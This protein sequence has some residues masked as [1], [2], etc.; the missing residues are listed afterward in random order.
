MSGGNNTPTT[1]LNVKDT[2][3]YPL[4]NGGS[5]T[6]IVWDSA[7]G[8]WVPSTILQQ[9]V[10]ILSYLCSRDSGASTMLSDIDI[11]SYYKKYD[12]VTHSR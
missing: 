4:N 3:V 7:Q 2:N 11:F 5:G 6:T 8:C 10:K 1:L 12:F 9:I